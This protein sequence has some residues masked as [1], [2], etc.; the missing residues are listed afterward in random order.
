MGRN[1]GNPPQNFLNGEL[2]KYN[3]KN[4]TPEQR[5][6]ISRKGVEARKKKKEQ[7]MLLQNCMWALLNM[8]VSS[9]QSKEILKRAGFKDD[10]DGINANLL[11]LALFK[12]GLTGDAGATKVILDMMNDLDMVKQGKELS[13]QTININLVPKGETYIPSDD[14]E[15]DIWKAENG[16]LETN[17]EDDDN[18]DMDSDDDNWGNEVYDG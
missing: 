11:M 13:G 10:T 5:K 14:D 12:K 9:N 4:L 1:K 15:E 2:D 3:F 18:W 7:T 6:E 8:N 17:N 16:I